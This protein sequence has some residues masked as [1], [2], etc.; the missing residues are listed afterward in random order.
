MTPEQLVTNNY[1]F[2]VNQCLKLTKAK[3]FNHS[4]ADLAHDVCLYL[5]SLPQSKIDAINSDNQQ[6][7]IYRIILWQVIN[8]ANPF[9]KTYRTIGDE[10]Q[11]DIQDTI[12]DTYNIDKITRL[13]DNQTLILSY[14][15]THGVVKLM[16][17]TGLRHDDAKRL[18]S[19]ILKDIR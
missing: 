12:P 16:K 14:Y 13:N 15:I 9:C 17:K 8:D 3:G 1:D 11:Y 6:G 4:C 10:I 18:I 5:L 7:Y 2:I 19:N